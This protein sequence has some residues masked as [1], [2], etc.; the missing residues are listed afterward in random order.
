MSSL[1][2]V[3]EGS[4]RIFYEALI[5]NKVIDKNVILS[6]GFNCEKG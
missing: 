2:A 4:E 3:E 6:G 5:Q 1:L